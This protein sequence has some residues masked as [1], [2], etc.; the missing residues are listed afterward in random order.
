MFPVN[1]NTLDVAHQPHIDDEGLSEM[2]VFNVIIDS[3][4]RQIVHAHPHNCITRGYLQIFLFHYYFHL[5]T[6]VMI[7]DDSNLL[8]LGIIL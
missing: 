1:S 3:S 6:S 4:V 8:C 5:K 7:N 2:V